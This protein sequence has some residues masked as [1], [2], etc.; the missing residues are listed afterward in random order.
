MLNEDNPDLRAALES[1]GVEV[2]PDASNEEVLKSA[3]EVIDSQAQE[4]KSV[5]A[6]ASFDSWQDVSA[7]KSDS[8]KPIA[9]PAEVGVAADV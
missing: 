2:A 4:V 9:E 7:W 8:G 6:P 1:T 3:L 5:D